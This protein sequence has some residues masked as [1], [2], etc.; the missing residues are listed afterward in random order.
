MK[1]SGSL[2]YDPS[3]YEFFLKDPV[4]KNIEIDKV[5]EQYMPKTKGLSQQL[6]SSV[7]EK[8]PV[9]RLKNNNLQHPLAK[10]LLKSITVKDEILYLVLGF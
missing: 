4:L 5:S 7:L 2:K 3:K 9:Y 1:V 6:I 10:S 8:K